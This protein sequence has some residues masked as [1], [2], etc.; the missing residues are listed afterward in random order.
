MRPK[1]FL[2]KCIHRNVSH[3]RKISFA[4]KYILKNTTNMHCA[5]LLLLLSGVS[6][7]L[8]PNMGLNK[9]RVR[10]RKILSSTVEVMEVNECQEDFRISDGNV[11]EDGQVDVNAYGSPIA[12]LDLSAGYCSRRRSTSRHHCS[13]GVKYKE[14]FR[15]GL[16]VFLLNVLFSSIRLILKSF[17][18]AAVTMHLERRNLQDRR[19]VHA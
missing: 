15:V 12:A 4:I 8:I 18:F 17:S 19:I 9:H 13:R 10:E 5:R 11:S 1:S 3:Q 14:D 6:F 2:G 16:R 7:Q